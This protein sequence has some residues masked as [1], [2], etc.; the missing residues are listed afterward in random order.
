MSLELALKVK[1]K[2]DDEKYVVPMDVNTI[3]W[4]ERVYF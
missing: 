3:I 2:E 4:G 1:Y